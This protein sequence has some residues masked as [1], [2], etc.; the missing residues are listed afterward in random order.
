MM[1]PNKP[2]KIYLDNQATTQVDPKVLD[3][4]LPWFTEKFGNAASRSHHFG[5]EA[6]EA[7]DIAREQISELISAVPQEIIFTSGA[8]EANNLVLKGSLEAS[9]NS[10]NHII[11]VCT[12]HKSILDPLNSFSAPDCKITFLGVKKDGI[13]DL[14]KLKN[15][16]TKQT[17]LVSIMH[18]NNEIGV[19]QPIA[20]IGKIC[21]EN[22]ILFDTDAAQSVGKIPIDVV[23]MNIDL[24]SISSHKMY[25]PKGVGVLY[26]RRKNPRVHLISQIE[27][28]GHE[29]GLR[30]GTLPV[31]LIVGFGKACELAQNSMYKESTKIAELRDLLLHGITENLDGVSINGS[32]KNRLPGNINLSFAGV[33]GTALL[34]GLSAIAVSSGSAC[35]SASPEPSYV[36]KALGLS[37][38]ESHASIRFGI[39]RFNTK[40]EISTAIEVVVKTVKRLRNE[41]PVKMNGTSTRKNISVLQN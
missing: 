21:K 13:I 5:W 40:A 27:G 2:K 38:E 6:Q 8:T 12:E 4:M 33:N 10:E 1:S 30:S 19:I 24:L 9:P 3:V 7:V 20:E 36:L 41:F 16:I 32:L 23:K 15:A 31:P 35:T 34:M 11:S 28:G 17:I 25:G 18:A 37:K 22:G 29:R 26:V 14:E 39:G